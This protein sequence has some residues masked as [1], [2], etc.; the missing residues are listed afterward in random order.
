MLIPDQI[1][2]YCTHARIL[3]GTKILLCWATYG[4]R[5]AQF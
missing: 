3:Q 2:M 1:N 4:D 5:N